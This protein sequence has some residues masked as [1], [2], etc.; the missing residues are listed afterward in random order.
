MT[1]ISFLMSYKF[2]V[3]IDVITNRLEKYMTFLLKKNLVFIDSMLLMNSSLEKLVK[4]LTD[5][6][7]KYLSEEFGFKNLELLKQE[8]AYLYECMENFNGEK[9]PGK[10]CFCSFVKDRTTDDNG[11]KLDGYISNKDYLTCKKIWNKFNMKNMG[12]YHDHY[13]KKDILLLA[14]VFENF[15]DTCLKL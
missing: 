15:I 1:V 12:D 11:K 4:N 9:L 13:L 7:F 8:D 14:D 3:K 6:D 10:K 2:D 5:D